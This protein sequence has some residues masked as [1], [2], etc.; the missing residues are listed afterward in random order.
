[1]FGGHP[2]AQTPNIDALAA[3][4][5]RFVNAHTNAPICGP[6]RSSF[7]TGIYPHRSGIYGFGNWYNPGKPGFS[8]N[9]VLQNSKTL[10]HYMRDNG[11]QSYG[12]GKLMHFDLADNYV[13][14]AGHPEAGNSQEFWDE[15]GA[16]AN[17]GPVAF[18][19]NAL[20]TDGGLGEAVNHP[21]IPTT[22]MKGRV[23]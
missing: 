16:K 14:P 2:Q 21:S 3:S 4:G 11:Y 5:V 9:T 6:S 12:T 19:P 7:I 20:N 15:Y 23:D 18:D 13:Y 22:F 17:Y 1:V 8:V 10:M